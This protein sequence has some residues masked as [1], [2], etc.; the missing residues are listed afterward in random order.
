ML[1]FNLRGIG[2]E[3]LVRR[4]RVD[5]HRIREWITSQSGIEAS[6]CR[7]SEVP[8][9]DLRCLSAAWYTVWAFDTGFMVV[10][11]RE[12]RIWSFRGFARSFLSTA[13]FGISI[14]GVA[15]GQNR[16]WNSGQPS[17][18]KIGQEIFGPN[19]SYLIGL[20][21]PDN[22]GELGVLTPFWSCTSWMN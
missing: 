12:C 9:P 13:V 22:L 11:F 1:D 2:P 5:C 17:F 21:N 10:N 18:P 16:I 20:A 4:N 14:P 3:D 6:G 8:I 15:D 19:E 7:G